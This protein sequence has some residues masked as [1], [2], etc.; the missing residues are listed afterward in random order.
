MA[1]INILGLEPWASFELGPCPKF[2]TRLEFW[3]GLYD[4]DRTT[5]RKIRPFITGQENKGQEIGRTG[6]HLP[7][8]RRPLHFFFD[9]SAQTRK[10]HGL[11][12]MGRAGLRVLASKL[13][14]QT[15][16]E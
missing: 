2:D 5:T 7:F 9:F 10:G 4:R 11:E 12:G 15:Y 8:H 1:S 14:R 3:I 6:I 16:L 13:N